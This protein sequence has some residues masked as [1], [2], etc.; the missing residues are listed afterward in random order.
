MLERVRDFLMDWQDSLCD[1]FEAREDLIR[2][3]RRELPGERGGLARPR[4][5]Q[6]GHRWERAAVNFSH[7]GGAEMPAAATVRRPELAG[8]RFEA[9]SVSTIVHPRNPYC[10]TA[11]A[12]F[13]WFG[14]T[15]A[16]G[17]P[18]WWFGGG[19]DLT[20]Y[21]GFD[22]DV[23]E[24]HQR[25]ADACAVLGPGTYAQ[26]KAHCDRYFHLPHRA[27]Q[28]G[29]GGIFFDDLDQPDF[30]SC[31]AFVQAAAHAYRDGLM[32][33]QDRRQETPYGEHER[34]F[35][36]VRRGRYVEFNLLHDRGTLFGLQAGG[37]IESILASM[38]PLTRWDYDFHPAP[39]TPEA[40]L[41]EHFL[42]PRD[43]LSPDEPV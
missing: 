7:T 4:V 3:D 8:A 16:S 29:V 43:W 9:V 2:F 1:A 5:L 18:V 23:R 11:H 32:A 12:N 17:D 35:Q 41:L 6:D 40:R 22:E 27:E 28:R 10:P 31:F 13:R 33:I 39:G 14:A 42:V 36:L 24:W 25:A 19:F 20:P 21:Y 15:P 34:H 37:R 38:P 30:E 26:F